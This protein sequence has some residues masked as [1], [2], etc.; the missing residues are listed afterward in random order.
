M[1]TEPE[2]Y[3]EGAP[4]AP[5]PK[6]PADQFM[7][8][9]D[10]AAA[11][12]EPDKFPRRAFIFLPR[13]SFPRK[14]AIQIVSSA[15]F[16]RGVLGLIMLNCIT[17]L[18]F[19]MPVLGKMYDEIPDKAIAISWYARDS[20]V[21]GAIAP[22]GAG[23]PG[24]S[25]C[26]LG[27]FPA[28][29]VSEYID[30][31]FLVL[32][33]M[34]MIAKML[35]SG[36]LLHPTAY[37]RSGWN[38]LDFIVVATGWIS[39]ADLGSGG[40][41]TNALRLF[42]ALRPLRSLQRIRGMR[43]LVNC[44]LAAI[45][46][47]C[48]VVVFLM[49][50][51]SVFGIIGVQL[52]KG[53]LRH[54]C[55]TC[56]GADCDINSNTGGIHQGWESTGAVCAPYCPRDDDTGVVT[57]PCDSLGN[58]TTVV[59][60]TSGRPKEKPGGWIWTCNPGEQC[61]CG[62]SGLVD[63]NCELTDNPNY[64]INHFDN[65]LWAM[66]S[67]FQAI[68]LEGWVDI[69]YTVMDGS[70]LFSFIYFLFV[71][72]LGALIVINLFLAVLCDN[73]NMADSDPE[74]GEEEEVDGEA[75]T[76]REMETLSWPN[77]VRQA[78][79]DMCKRP[80]FNQVIFG[81]ICLNTILMMVYFKPQPGNGEEVLTSRRDYDYMPEALW[82]TLWIFNATLTAIFVAESAIKLIG[83]GPR[84]FVKDS[85]NIFDIVVVFV[86]LIE[87]SLDIVGQVSDD[88][89][90][91][92]PGLSVLRAFR[93]FR[94]LKLVRSVPSLRR[95]L[96][97][98]VNSIK[99]VF[100]LFLL[101]LLMMVIFALLGMELFGGYYPRP[102]YHYTQHSMPEVFE[103]KPHNLTNF[104]IPENQAL[105]DA[106]KLG[107]DCKIKWGTQTAIGEDMTRYNFDSFGDAFLSIFV[108]LSG[109]NWNEI[110][111]AQHR[112]TWDDGLQGMFATIYFL[113]LFVVGNLLLF[114]LFIAILL[115]NFDDDD[116]EEEE[117]EDEL[118]DEIPATAN[119]GADGSIGPP[120][121][122][123][124]GASKKGGAKGG[125]DMNELLT[126]QFGVYRNQTEAE[127]V[128]KGNRRVSQDGKADESVNGT[129]TAT[130]QGRE[131]QHGG[132]PVLPALP[133]PDE[134]SGDKSLKMF[135]WSNPVRRFCAALVAHPNFDPVVVVLIIIS[136]LCLAL[137]WP[138]YD[139]H[140]PFAEALAVL[141]KTFTVL[142][143]IECILKVVAMGL[144]H[145]KNKKYP[146][147]LRSGWN[148]LDFVVV[149]ISL[150]SLAG[151]GLTLLKT[152]RALRP[153]RLISR[154]ED[155]KQCVDTLMQS[156]PAMSV[157]MTVAG[158]FFIIFGILGVELFGGRFG[159]CLDP[160]A[161]G[162]T[163]NYKGTSPDNEVDY[164]A[165][166]V[167]G[168]NGSTI[169]SGPPY[170]SDY[171]ECMAIP[172]YYIERR[173]TNG[174][175]MSDLVTSRPEF[176][177]YAEFPQWVN[178]HF[179]NFD[180][181]MTSLLLI[182]EVSALE[183]WPDVMHMAMD[184]DMNEMYVV[185]W[186]FDQDVDP[187]DLTDNL[188]FQHTHAPNR[189]IAASYMVAWIILG[190]FV[191]M[192][193]TIGVV[194]DTFSKIREEN[195]GCALMSEDQAEWVK[196][197]KQVFAMRPLRQAVAPPQ[198][199]RQAFFEVV[200]S[201]KFDVFIMVTI[202]I[203]MLIMGLDLHDPGKV[204]DLMDFLKVCNIFFTA[205]YI[206]EMIAKMIGFGP[207]QY[208][209]DGW[210]TFDFTLVMLSIFDLTLS[211]ISDEELPFPAPLVRVLRLFRVV[212]ILR[213][214]KT[215]KKLRAIIMTVV[216]SIPA[217]VN[218]GL[219]ILLMLFIYAVFCVQQFAFVN[220]TPGNWGE[221]PEAAGGGTQGA[222]SGGGYKDPSDFGN[223]Y[224]DFITRHANFENFGMALLTLAR[225]VTGESFNGIMHDVMGG[226]W[227]DNRLRCCS[228]CGPIVDGKP[229]DSCGN[230][231][232]ALLIFLSFQMIMAYII[233]SL[234]IGVI[235]ENFANVGSETK[236]IT[237]EQLEEFREV[238]LK[239]DPK[240]TFTVPSHNLLAILQQLRK[241]L[242]I[243]G[244]EPA[245][246]RSD[247][248]KHLGKLDI[249]DHGGVIHFIETLT[250]VSHNHAGVPVPMC[251]TTRKL[252][253]SMQKVPK[254]ATLE[255]P[256]HNALTNYL[257]S[258][259]QSRWRGYAMRKKYSGE[260]GY[261]ENVPELAADVAQPGAE[262]AAGK[263]KG[264][265][266][267]P[268][269]PQ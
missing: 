64:G 160:G 22:P 162:A 258:L 35:A 236:K 204:G 93:I 261:D 228:E 128:R 191:V 26:Q 8:V 211:N 198:P 24:G 138:G 66:V 216:I 266:V 74:M 164:G 177:M 118:D 246:T 178:P 167:P 61:R 80:I 208:F 9:V 244:I 83:L 232:M 231:I 139:A 145:S 127:E 142:F 88:F 67:L 144:I 115:S 134:P 196:A 183:G 254:V 268:A 213:I 131:S 21:R 148:V 188:G 114:N 264:N 152:L 62:E 218:I 245:L 233:M 111:F 226:E 122:A 136:S 250:A 179:G 240:G 6:N 209:Q 193:M 214:I 101:L 157:L 69:M 262:G 31:V 235:L 194:V 90:S 75:E 146:A 259:L 163:Y 15:T 73:F 89:G 91:N 20:W 94:L 120:P 39:M 119:V 168:V 86:S 129:S 47:L 170:Q 165:R 135:S 151:A 38:W 225:C 59:E 263:V 42:K 130:E 45:P 199:W 109:E 43:V 41:G 166:V 171:E 76:K 200:T 184:S 172:K 189:Y 154:Y 143:T 40:G 34:E 70:G 220:Y 107:M 219:L 237:M 267:A 50:V 11:T 247:M 242:G 137:D 206:I 147:Y 175:L 53:S 222:A 224:G 173:I 238:W 12:I 13:N 81:C 192:N 28:C 65:V 203:N 156:I 37:L 155:L 1:D 117:M 56:E 95:I 103:C 14:Q 60:G 98:L 221:G 210:N 36:L 207:K 159:Y 102:E 27:R 234:A 217:L 113:I 79:L 100:Y 253:K 176:K 182:F 201:N 265:Q 257:V 4:T 46:Q 82:R 17:M 124:N 23:D 33:S 19:S 71:I 153:L 212:R 195:D 243:V 205:I 227:G 150:V 202:F 85:F 239:Y 16:E 174:T 44:I 7:D 51:L 105:A 161:D 104:F 158:L 87:L 169:G 241:P 10:Q 3:P 84:L 186:R 78:C 48:T 29:S 269:P 230:T 52:F 77:P 63:P 96:A 125:I 260:E 149:L 187:N 126:Y 55:F 121:S 49:F 133:P 190:C 32:F 58:L 110:Y 181:I 215:A 256:A 141:D 229:T 180:W 248:L 18:L 185:P 140:L 116:E 2:A 92:I 106:G 251:D 108:V 255:K 5:M 197:Q 249:P 72:I 112:A 25:A 97:T 252:Q 68:S 57:G 54:Q 99:S 132:K 30:F 223:N 123:A